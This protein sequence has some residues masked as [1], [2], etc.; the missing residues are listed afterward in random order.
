M[1]LPTITSLACLLAVLFV[2]PVRGVDGQEE[3][4]ADENCA[5]TPPAGWRHLDSMNQ[6]GCFAAFGNADRSRIVLLFAHQRGRPAA[7]FGDAGVESFEQG[8]TKAGGGER[9]S[10]KFVEM[11]GYRAYERR[12]MLSAKGNQ[13]SSL[14]IAMPT[15]DGIYLLEALA[16]GGDAG[17]DAAIRQTL[18]TF[19][20]LHPPGPPQSAAYRLGYLLGQIGFAVVVVGLVIGLV[21]RAI[22]RNRSRVS[23]QPSGPY[24][25][26]SGSFPPPAPPPPPLPPSPR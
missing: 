23:A 17:E 25:F 19:R 26:P 9:L 13:M 6:P 11:A 1:R 4:F 14:M 15:G 7:E 5:L 18:G 10:G 2:L 3:A 12:G 8:V 20:F 21:V 24:P 16:V 22:T